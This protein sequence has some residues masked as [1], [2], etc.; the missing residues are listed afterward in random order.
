MGALSRGESGVVRQ[1][2]ASQLSPLLPSPAMAPRPR[3][4]C[5]LPR[6]PGQPWQQMA[7]RSLGQAGASRLEGAANMRQSRSCPPTAALSPLTASVSTTFSW[8]GANA[9]PPRTALRELRSP[10]IWPRAPPPPPAA[11]AQAAEPPPCMCQACP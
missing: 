3:D 6:T 1:Q 9:N 10:E 4:G 7:H 2:T 5:V 8:V 11:P